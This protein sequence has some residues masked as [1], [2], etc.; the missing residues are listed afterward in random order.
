MEESGK[1][2]THP[3]MFGSGNGL[4]P[5]KWDLH[6]QNSANRVCGGVGDVEALGESAGANQGQNMEWDQVDQEDIA[7]PA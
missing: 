5:N 2:Q 6:G 7:T 3:H 1:W 4:E